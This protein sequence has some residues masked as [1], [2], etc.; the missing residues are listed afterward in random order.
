M[1]F[2]T[3]IVHATESAHWHD[4]LNGGELFAFALCTI[5]FG[6]ALAAE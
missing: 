2:V 1:L 6:L 5:I 3:G 4:P